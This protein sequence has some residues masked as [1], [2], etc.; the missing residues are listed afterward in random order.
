MR[1]NMM[2]QAGNNNFNLL[3]STE[4]LSKRKHPESTVRKPYSYMISVE[5]R[6]PRFIRRME[7]VPVDPSSNILDGSM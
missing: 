6:L 1:G 3:I 4:K 2:A 5:D 7:E